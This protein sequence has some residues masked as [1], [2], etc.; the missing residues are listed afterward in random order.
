MY[1]LIEHTQMLINE[2]G[3]VQ[4]NMK[5]VQMSMSWVG[6]LFNF[7]IMIFRVL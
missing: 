3:N 1:S 7:L 4:M 5:V 2:Y 6:V